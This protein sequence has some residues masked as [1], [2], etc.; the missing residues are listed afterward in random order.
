MINAYKVLV[1][2]SG[3]KVPL[4][5]LQ[6]RWKGDTEIALKKIWFEVWTGIIGFR[7]RVQ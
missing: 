7:S 3:R 2:N 4:G 5:R 6:G 1:R